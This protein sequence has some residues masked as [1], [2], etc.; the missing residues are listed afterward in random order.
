MKYPDNNEYDGQWENGN[1]SGEAVVTYA[2]EGIIKRQLWKDN[3]RVK[4][5][6]TLQDNN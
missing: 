1:K 5:L 3:K 2:K 4:V 6:E